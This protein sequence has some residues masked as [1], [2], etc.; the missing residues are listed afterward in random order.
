MEIDMDSK[1]AAD[2]IVKDIDRV[3]WEY[4][5]KH[6]EPTPAGREWLVKEIAT[7]IVYQLESRYNLDTND[8]LY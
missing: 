7:E 1:K 6:A 2:K 3:V 8:N 4:V 5:K